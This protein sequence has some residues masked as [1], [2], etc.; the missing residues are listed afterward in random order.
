[1]EAIAR[2]AIALILVANQL[3]AASPA[4]NPSGPEP[5]LFG[6]DQHYPVGNRSTWEQPANLIGSY[7]HLD[8][9]FPTHR[10]RHGAG[11]SGFRRALAEPDL[12]YSFGGRQGTVDSYLAHFPATGLLLLQGDTILVERYQYGRKASDRFMAQSM[13]K[14]VLALLVGVAIGE[15]RIRSVEDRAEQ[16]VPQLRGS[17]YGGT[18]LRTLLQMSSGVDFDPVTSQGAP[19]PDSARLKAGLFQPGSDLAAEL[20][21]CNRRAAPPGTRFSYSSGDNET[22]AIALHRAVQRTLADYLSEKIW[23]PM[24]AEADA[25]WLTDTSDQEY[26][27]Y[28]FSATLR[29]Y[30]RLGR[31][32]ANDGSFA[33][34][35]LIPRQWLIDATTNHPGDQQLM[36]GAATPYYGYGYQIW[37]LPGSRRMFVLRGALSQYV[38][39]DPASRLVLVQTAVRSEA[40]NAVNGKSETLALW[41]AAVKQL[42]R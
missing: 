26:T 39:V 21:K 9:I 36:P 1:M 23:Q 29:D 19:N 25:T 37:I 5:A 11:V 7:S 33:G 40:P 38:F 32:L 2:G 16:Y 8:Q 22:V 20:A 14:S 3:R 17:L 30:A 35:Q 24:G 15:G 12:H 27:F 18:A 10:V 42:G 28:G 4:F 41:L 6:A 31:L 13:T 34:K